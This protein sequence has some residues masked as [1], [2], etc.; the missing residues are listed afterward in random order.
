MI[1]RISKLLAA[2][3]LLA[4]PALAE[5]VVVKG[6]KVW[7]GTEQGTLTNG[8]VVFDEGRVV[9]V[10]GAD[11]V[12]PEGA[13]TITA[14]Y[15][16]PGLISA[17]SR[18]GLVEV[19]AESSTNDISSG[20]SPFSVAINAA[21][22]FNPDATTLPITRLDGVTRIVVAPAASESIFAGQGFVADTSGD[23][24]GDLTENAFLL[25]SMG[26]RGASL[27]G[28]SRPSAWAELRASFDDVRNFA[29]RYSGGN[30]DGTV[31][32]RT[33]AIALA[34]AVRGAQLIV[35]EAHRASD[36]N[37]IMD[38]KDANPVIRVA[39]L[40][41]DEAWRVAPRLAQMNIP[42]ILDSFSNLPAS[43]SQLGATSENAARLVEAGVRI[44]IVNL[45][46]D[47][48]QARLAVQIAGNA[49]ANGLDF[50]DAMKALTV[51]PADIF[52][53]PGLGVLRPGAR[54]DIVAWDGDPL[55]VTSSPE[56]VFIDGTQQSLQSRQTRLRDRYLT[57]A[58][59]DLPQAY[60]KP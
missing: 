24:D 44:A 58:P 38:F 45:G 59:K 4:T 20:K 47:S 6:E 51:T 53:M 36:L 18:T 26:E 55:E 3:A 19:S 52:G 28:G 35:F 46:D 40:G 22:G 7:T 21:D 14:K 50:D 41:G 12:V 48:H 57:L 11:T 43:F 42:V 34:P 15:V 13:R 33:D 27:A 1:T 2:A 25:V 17:F 54:A 9:A 32:N 56:A 30:N 23:V 16:T 37:A 29:A 60:V 39:I 49:V 10:G 8:V 31:L 5:P